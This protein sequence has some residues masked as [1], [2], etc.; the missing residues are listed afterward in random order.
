MRIA[1]VTPREYP[2]TFIQAHL[3]L[4]EGKKFHLYGYYFPSAAKDQPSLLSS[5]HKLFAKGMIEIKSKLGMK[6]NYTLL[7]KGLIKY[8]CNRNIDV[9]LAEYG[10]TG[11]EITPV[12]KK[13]AIP[14]VVHF[15]GHDAVRK[16]VL[17]NYKDKYRAMFDYASYIVVVSKD[18]QRQLKSLGAPGDKLI[19]NTYGPQ[20]IFSSVIPN[21]ESNQFLFIG[22]FVDKKAPYLTILAFKKVHEKFPMSRLIMVGDDYLLNACRV[23]AEALNLV[24]AIKFR[25]R[26]THQKILEYMRDSFCYVQHSIVADDGDSEGTPVSI[27][28]AA[29][30]G[31][32]VIS[33]K[34]AGIK[35]AVKHGET[36]FL[37]EEKD[38]QLMSK[39]MIKLFSD[40]K[41]AKQM[42]GNAKEFIH[43]NYSMN[44]HINK[45]QQIL[46]RAAL[47]NE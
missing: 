36:G 30:A 45:L 38:V 22:R 25:G 12:L 47:K 1:I 24:P 15:H 35:D 44:K 29:A 31:L 10:M 46:E 27:L 37:V 33:T 17:Y 2:E 4:I 3:D 5:N 8:L 9:F 11:A 6:N 26:L 16:K 28:E 32:P 7:E 19:L 41:L 21:Y 43:Q 34:H 20:K 40:R 39:Y 23:L 13:F 18:M 14:L 42:G